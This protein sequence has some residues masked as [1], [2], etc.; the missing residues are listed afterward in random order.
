MTYTTL[1]QGAETLSSDDRR[2]GG[3]DSE[4]LHCDG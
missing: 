1:R 2:A 4:G 3:K